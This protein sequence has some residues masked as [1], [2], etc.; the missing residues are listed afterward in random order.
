MRS[1]VLF[2]VSGQS[3][4][5]Y[6]SN[7]GVLFAFPTASPIVFQSSHQKQTH[8]TFHQANPGLSFLLWQWVLAFLLS[9]SLSSTEK[10]ICLELESRFDYVPVPTELF[11]RWKKEYMPQRWDP[12]CSLLSLFRSAWTAK[13]SFYWMVSIIT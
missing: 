9:Y 8:T 3:Q 12:S 4:F 5:Q 7:F 11:C 2:N 10:C 13:L 6:Y 1:L